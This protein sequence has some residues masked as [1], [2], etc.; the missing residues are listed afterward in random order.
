[1]VT[2]VGLRARLM[3]L[4]GPGCPGAGFAGVERLGHSGYHGWVL[5]DL[6]FRNAGGEAVPAFFLR[7][8]EGHA[9]VPAAIYAH[10]HGNRYHIGRDELLN[11]RPALQSP[12]APDLVAAGIATLCIEM[13]CFGARA[14]PGES[15]RV[16]AA[17]WQGEPLFAQMLAEQVA[18]VDFLTAHPMVRGDRIGT[19]GFSM[20]STLAFWLAALEPRIRACSALCS[21]ADLATLVER[22]AHD[23]HGHYMTVPGLLSV[24]RTGQI[25]G[26]IAPRALQIG[27]GL[28]DWSTP[29]AAVAVARNDLEAAYSRGGRLVM[30]VDPDAGHEETT[31]MRAAVLKF[32][33]EELAA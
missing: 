14:E 4:L 29:E 27:V 13:P 20:G 17:L 9:P 31:A 30:H 2:D 10:A 11:G 3:A 33:A 26:L 16:K 23:G 6:L 22:G 19:L 7:P 1:L 5:E 12:Y 24:A 25:A 18:G 32:L 15:A 8:P 21:F 28:Q